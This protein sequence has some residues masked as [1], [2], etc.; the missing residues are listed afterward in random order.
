[1]PEKV[2]EIARLVR[3]ASEPWS[4]K[5]HHLFPSLARSYAAQLLVVGKLAAREVWQL[6][7]VWEELI[8]PLLVTRDSKPA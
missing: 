7:D 5:T 4:A 2:L 8:M 3:T 6:A 1:M